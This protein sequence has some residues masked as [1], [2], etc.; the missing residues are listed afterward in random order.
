MT[1]VPKWVKSIPMSQSH[2]SGPL[3]KRLWTLTSDYVRIRDFHAFE[4]QCVAVRGIRIAHWR[5]GDA[6]H[7][8]SYAVCNGM[9]KFNPMN[10]HLQSKSSNGW[11]GQ[12]IGYSFGEELKRRYGDSYLERIEN[13]N[14]RTPLKFTTQDI[15]TQMEVLL[16]EME[17]LKEQP[18]YYKKVMNLKS[19]V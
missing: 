16:G 3:Q 2:G 8:K 17:K 12:E 6:G 14:R 11:G 15:L 19:K 1:R 18:D 10:I 13:E 7:Y 5:H 4:G 9:F